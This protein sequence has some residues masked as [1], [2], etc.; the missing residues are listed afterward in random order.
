[1][2]K[3]FSDL[4]GILNFFWEALANAWPWFSPVFIPFVLPAWGIYMVRKN[5]KIVKIPGYVFL[6]LALLGMAIWVYGELHTPNSPFFA[7]TKEELIWHLKYMFEAFFGFYFGVFAF[8][9][10]R[11]WIK[12]IG[13]IVGL[14][15]FFYFVVMVYFCC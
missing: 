3:Y 11:V 15:S 2:E 12:I 7:K 4:W 8:F 6:L 14:I 10:K 13:V 9:A 5:K 1:M